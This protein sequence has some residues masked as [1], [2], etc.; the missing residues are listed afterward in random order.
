MLLSYSRTGSLATAIAKTFDGRHPCLLCKAIT[1]GEQGGKKQDYQPGNGKIDM[2]FRR[3]SA[4]LDPPGCPGNGVVL[5][6]TP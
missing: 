4:L 5:R 2:D 6:R 1:K 3:P